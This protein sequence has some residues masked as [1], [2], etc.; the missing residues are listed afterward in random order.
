MDLGRRKY[1]SATLSP[2]EATLR[3][4]RRWDRLQHQILF[5]LWPP[6]PQM[7]PR[8]VFVPGHFGWIRRWRKRR[9]PF[10]ILSAPPCSIW[11]KKKPIITVSCSQRGGGGGVNVQFQ[12]QLH[13]RNRNWKIWTIT[14]WWR[15][16]GIITSG[17][18]ASAFAPLQLL[19][20]SSVLQRSRRR[21]HRRQFR[22]WEFCAILFS[23]RWQEAWKLK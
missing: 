19:L 17:S 14:F 1:I 20:R 16:H 13:H 10:R 22:W 21:C 6:T 2:F 7:G 4:R 9:L 11:K 5:R 3:R 23:W 15:P 8:R 18:S 12:L